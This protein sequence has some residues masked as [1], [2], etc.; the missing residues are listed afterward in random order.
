MVLT[1]RHACK[2]KCAFTLIELL[3]VISIIAILI[4]ILLPTLARA[5]FHAKV[6]MC[7]SNLKQIGLGLAVYVLDNEDQ[8]PIACMDNLVHVYSTYTVSVGVD[9]RPNLLEI[10]ANSASDLYFCPLSWMRPELSPTS[11]AYSTDFYVDNTGGSNVHMITYGMYFML[12]DVPGWF[13]W[14]ASETP[15]GPY[16]PYDPLAAIVG[17]GNGAA[18]VG[19]APRP[20]WSP[21]NADGGG[22]T[23][24][25]FVN[26]N[27]LYGDGRVET[28]GV[29]LDHWVVRYGTS[30][31]SW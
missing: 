19:D 21:H 5:K 8:Y 25:P 16:K 17:D 23:P 24:L 1:L 22:G 27:A 12:D 13:D 10:S 4:S 3:V 26:S 9:N 2:S 31:W 30:F 29:A 11:N 15:Q 20:P 7:S 14:S 18:T 6:V 28:H